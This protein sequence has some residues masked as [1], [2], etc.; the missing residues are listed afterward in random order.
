MNRLAVALIGSF[1]ITTIYGFLAV[2]L[3]GLIVMSHCVLSD[4]EIAQGATCVQL[5][6]VALWSVLL[7]EIV[8][9]VAILATFLRWAL[10]QR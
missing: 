9:F 1:L 10:K 4:I 5:A 7:I 2:T 3:L 8:V 6:D